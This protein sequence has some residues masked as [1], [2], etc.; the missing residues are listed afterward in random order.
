M[1]RF[2]AITAMAALVLS[3]GLPVWATACTHMA[4]ANDKPPMCHRTVSHQ[5][6]CEMMSGQTEST[7]SQGQ[8]VAVENPP[9]ECPM[10][11]CMQAQAGNGTAVVTISAL[12]E[13]TIAEYLIHAPAIVFTASGFSSRTDRGP[14]AC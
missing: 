2:L 5:H 6:H 7:A 3:T 11:C 13:L 8:E 4:M 1:R 10:Q 14:P 9:G 12:P